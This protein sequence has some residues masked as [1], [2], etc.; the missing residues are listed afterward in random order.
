MDTN[1]AN[2]YLG[3]MAASWPA[4]SM[5]VRK[6]ANDMEFHQDVVRDEMK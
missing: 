3:R 6:N 1:E 4:V 5:N 2:Y